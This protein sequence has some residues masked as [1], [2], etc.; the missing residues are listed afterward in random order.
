MK[1]NVDLEELLKKAKARYEAMTP[2]EK[3]E[4]H[5][6]QRKSWVKGETML[7]HPEMSEDEFE[8][9]WQKVIS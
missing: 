7:E 4:M 5:A 6:I 9:I 2:K 3:A 8:L 1:Q